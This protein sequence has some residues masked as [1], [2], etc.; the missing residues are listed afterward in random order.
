MTSYSSKKYNKRS[1]QY[2]NNRSTKSSG[3]YFLI[4]L[5]NLKTIGGEVL[6]NQKYVHT[7][8]PTLLSLLFNF[9]LFC[10]LYKCMFFAHNG[11]NQTSILDQ[12]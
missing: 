5:I 9:F 12:H 2:D 3:G 11:T 1:L 4:F 8:S 10:L 6:P 7:I